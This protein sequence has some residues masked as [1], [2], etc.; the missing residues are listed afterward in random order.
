MKQSGLILALI[1]C[2]IALGGIAVLFR[3]DGSSNPPTSDEQSSIEQPSDENPDSGE[4][5]DGE[6]VPVNGIKLN[7][8]HLVF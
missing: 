7:G 3:I 5:E 6:Y 2:L 4:I 8:N 1:L